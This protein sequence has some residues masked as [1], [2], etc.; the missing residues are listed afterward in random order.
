MVVII[1]WLSNLLTIFPLVSMSLEACRYISSKAYGWRELPDGSRQ[2][3][4]YCGACGASIK[5]VRQTETIETIL[6]TKR[7]DRINNQY[8]GTIAT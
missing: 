4:L 8:C 3:I 7:P 6:G 1:E 2:P 5:D